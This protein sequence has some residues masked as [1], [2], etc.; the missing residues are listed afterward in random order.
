MKKLVVGIDL[1]GTNIRGTLSDDDGNFMASF[2]ESADFSSRE[3]M[4]NQIIGGI[5]SLCKS[6]RVSLSSVAGVGI[7]STGP[8]NIKTGKLVRPTNIPFSEVNLVRPIRTRLGVQ[9]TLLNDCTAAVLGEREFGAGKRYDNLVYI[10]IGTGIG[11]GAIVDGHLLLGKD[12]NAVEIGHVVVDPDG[13]MKC[14]C[15][16]AGHWEAYCSGKNIPKYVRARVDENPQ[17]PKGSHL[18]RSMERG[19]F[20]APAFFEAVRAGDPHAKS[21]LDEISR[22]NAIG[23][24]DVINAYD[25]SLIT[26]GGSVVLRDEDLV[27]DP[28]VKTVRDYTRN[29]I[30]RIKVSPLGDDIGLYGAVASVLHR[31]EILGG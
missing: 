23:V 31:D 26:M 8:L 10:T 19:S 4:V 30:P 12:G 25:P 14:G 16:K 11:G 20:E 7:A 3:G 9:V 1:G 27:I 28:I 6:A 24:A 13:R 17:I 21:I 18:K 29:R 15:G 22:F 5:L 2:R